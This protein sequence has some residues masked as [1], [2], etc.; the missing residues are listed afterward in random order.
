MSQEPEK[1]AVTG[2]RT[3]RSRRVKARFLPFFAAAS[4][5]L[6]CGEDPPGDTGESSSTSSEASSTS[7]ETSSEGESSGESGETGDGGVGACA[8]PGGVMCPPSGGY[9][10]VDTLE[11]WVD[12][13]SVQI[14]DVRDASEYDAGH[15]PGAVRLDAGALRATVDG[16]SG[17]V[18]DDASLQSVF[19]AAG[20][21]PARPVVVYDASI[22]TDPARVVWTLAYAGHQAPVYLLDGGYA[23]WA[24]AGAE[25]ES[26]AN[27]APLPDYAL[28]KALELRVDGAWVFDHL[29]DASVTLID[30]RSDAEFTA[31]HIPGALSVDWT[32]NVDGSGL[33]K[34]ATDLLSLYA[35][36]DPGQTL[37]VYCVTG[38][39]ASVGWVVLRALGFD[40]VRLYDGSWTEWSANTAWPVEPG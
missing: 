40:D 21:D 11:L 10:D 6:A 26:A 30:A 8:E 4:L 15:V 16:V 20:L 5:L 14:V 27:D 19:A 2:T 24:A 1:L 23:A 33:F 35:D 34:A 17:Q 12:T 38:S 13:D 39:R 37:V 3:R 18:A 32:S 29:D 36:P 7:S 25:V 22:T 31:G 9:V 28:A